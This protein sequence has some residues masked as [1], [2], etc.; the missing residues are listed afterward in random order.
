MDRDTVERL[1]DRYRETHLESLGANLPPG[2]F[3]HGGWTQLVGA[4]YERRIYAFR[5]QTTAEQDDAL[6]QKL[7]A[8]PN[9]THFDL[10]FS[11]CADFSRVRPQST[12]FLT[13]S[14]AASSPMPA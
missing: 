12:T 8:G 1:R 7:N 2:N 11:N 9:R 14:G 13:P 3:V 6:I 10:L 4:A 5:F